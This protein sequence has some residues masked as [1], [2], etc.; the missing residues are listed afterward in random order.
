MVIKTKFALAAV[1]LASIASLT[2]AQARATGRESAPSTEVFAP[3]VDERFQSA[4][5]RLRSDR[6]FMPDAN[7]VIEEDNWPATEISDHASSP[8]AGGG[9]K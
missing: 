1:L 9:G 3:S 8:Y 4:P 2:S 6:A 7:Q 5:A